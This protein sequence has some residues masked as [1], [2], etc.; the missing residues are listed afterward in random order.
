MKQLQRFLG[1]INFFRRFL[2]KIAGILHPL[3][4]ALRGKPRQLVWTSEMHAAFSQAKQALA[5]AVSL[6]H[7]D[8]TATLA[9]ATDASD[10]HVGGVLQQR[11]EGSWQPLAFFSSKLNSAQCKYSTFDRELFAAYMAVR[12]FRLLLEGR[13]FSAAHGSQTS[14]GSYSPCFSSMVC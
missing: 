12:H 8:P 9:L 3:T 14:G 6:A 10:K 13:D 7:P 5:T 4:D 1:M 11:R 2:P